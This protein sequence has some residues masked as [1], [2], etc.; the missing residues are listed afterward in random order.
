MRAPG[1]GKAECVAV[2]P[3]NTPHST[4]DTRPPWPL[5]VVVYL[6]GYGDTLMRSGNELRQMAEMGLGGRRHG[7][8]PDQCGGVRG[9]VCGVAGL[10]GAAELGGYPAEIRK[11]IYTTNA[12]ESL[13]R[14][15]RKIS[16]NRGVFP[17]EESIF[18]L[19]YMALER[20]AKKW[21]MPIHNWSAAL[22][23]FAIEFGDRMP[24][25]N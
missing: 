10:S 25:P 3:K 18:K 13:N 15:L 12:I 4:P 20:I 17:H 16:K 6:H 2:L 5:P 23:R 21:T 1:F 14:S 24:Q 8:Q 19:Y 7:I 11:A 9:G 22:N